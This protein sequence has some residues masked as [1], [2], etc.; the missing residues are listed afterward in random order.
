MNL[1]ALLKVCKCVEEGQG[2]SQYAAWLLPFFSLSLSLLL[3]YVYFLK[4]KLSL[5]DKYKKKKLP[6]PV[7]YTPSL[8][9]FFYVFPILIF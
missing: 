9:P 7:I 8:Y 2:P 1:K 3:N 6:I 4:R 5:M